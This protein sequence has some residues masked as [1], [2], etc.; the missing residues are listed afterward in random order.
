MDFAVAIKNVS[1]AY[2]DMFVLKDIN[3]NIKK[4]DYVGIIG[5]NGTG[6]STLIKLMLGLLQPR[7]GSV[8][9]SAGKV[10]Y[11]PQVGLS[12]RSDFPATV[13]EIVSLNLY[14]EAKLFK[15][16]KKHHYDMV[17]KTLELVGMLSHKNRLIS[18]LSGGQKQR[19][20]IA[21]ALVNQPDILILDEPIAGIDA[22]S[23]AIFY[24]LLNRLNKENELTII[25]VTHNIQNV[26]KDMNQIF[27]I[28]NQGITPLSGK[29]NN[30]ERCVNP[31]AVPV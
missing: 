11:V 4:G 5:P 9:I 26:R 30:I 23:E 12:I 7:F 28:K 27:E 21:K 31:Y 17:D 24:E 14:S 6:K 16:L 22:E 3:L 20:L 25:M 13:K 2:D 29:E 19:V 8:A 1:F 18:Q 10:G 15:H